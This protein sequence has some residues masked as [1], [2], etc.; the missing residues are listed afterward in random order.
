MDLYNLSD[1]NS[2]ISQYLN[3]IRDVKIQQDCDSEPI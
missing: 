1:Q 3:E 2:L